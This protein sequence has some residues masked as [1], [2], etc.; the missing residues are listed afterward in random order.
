[1]YEAMQPT[2]AI[3]R[4]TVQVDGRAARESQAKTKKASGARCAARDGSN[5]CSR[6]TGTRERAPRFG[7]FDV[8]GLSKRARICS[9][10]E[11]F[12]H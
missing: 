1:M 11:T 10:Q 12:A 9:C 7:S 5:I 2:D 6:N 8:S 3:R 4:V